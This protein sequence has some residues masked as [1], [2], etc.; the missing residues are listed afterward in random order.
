MALRTV[1]TMSLA[2]AAALVIAAASVL[3]GTDNV[4]FPSNYKTAFTFYGTVDRA[5]NKTV[6]DL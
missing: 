3:A 2:A 5:D 4:A 6:R 1:F